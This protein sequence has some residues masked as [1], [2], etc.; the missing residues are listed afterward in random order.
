MD[1]GTLF[2]DGNGTA[3]R[4]GDAHSGHR[5][6]FHATRESDGQSSCFGDFEFRVPAVDLF[7]ALKSA[8]A[9]MQ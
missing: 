8:L 6:V 2:L 9:G 7:D 1:K 4:R 5:G 3:W